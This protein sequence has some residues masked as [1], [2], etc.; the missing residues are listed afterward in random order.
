MQ[1]VRLVIGGILLWYGSLYLV[2]TIAINEL[3][4]NAVALEF[5]LSI[6]DII[7][8]CF[9]PTRMRA[10]IKSAKHL[11]VRAAC[12]TEGGLDFR[13]VASFLVCLAFVLVVYFT[14]LVPMKH[15]LEK[16]QHAMC[17]GDLCENSI[18]SMA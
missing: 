17:G 13:S 18:A 11:R 10:L 9:A 4:L 15:R 2:Y 6:D 14:E 5:V 16:A 1:L 8:A 7:F 3:I 12:K